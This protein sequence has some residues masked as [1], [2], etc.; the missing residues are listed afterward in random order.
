MKR[1]MVVVLC[2]VVIAAGAGGA[3]WHYGHTGAK[4]PTTTA[5]TTTQ[6]ASTQ[7]PKPS[8]DKTQYSLTDPNS[9][10]VIVNKKNPLKP[11]TYV[12]NDLIFPTVPTRVPGNV[13]MQMRKVAGTA[14]ET[15]F[16]GAKKD[17]INLMLSS[18]YRP[19]TFQQVLYN[20]YVASSGV[21]AA[22]TF[23]ARP[24]YSEH[25]TGLAADI[26][27]LSEK[28]DVDQCFANLPEGKWLAANAYKYGFVI[29]Y[30]KGKDS[31]T[32]YEYEPWHVR[33]VGV[34]AATEMQKEDVVTLETFFGLPPAPTY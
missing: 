31:V 11:K 29:R 5:K 28:C 16:A 25:Q 22:D 26:E 33:Y 23:S 4:Q 15:M 20:N 17:G 19:Y 7:P 3:W 9:I 6:A 2:I 34:E 13:S 8:F 30:P 18:G 27:P 1:F 12:P 32:G 10:W 14:L 24:G 21:A